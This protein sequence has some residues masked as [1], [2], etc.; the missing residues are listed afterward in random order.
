MNGVAL[1]EDPIAPAEIRGEFKPIATNTT[2]LQLGEVLPKLAQQSQH[3]TLVRSIG[4]D[5]KG[6]RNHG[7]AIY[8]LMT[9]HSPTNFSP[10]GLAVPPSREDLPSVGANV[11][12]YRPAQRGRFSNVAAGAAVMEGR[13]VGVGQSA[14]LHGAAFDPYTIY[15]DGDALGTFAV[16][17]E[18][19]PA[20]LDDADAW[21]HDLGV[22]HSVTGTTLSV[23]RTA[24]VPSPPGPPRI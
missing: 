3:Y 7:A 22:T 6:L 15:D 23:V 20:D 18:Q 9:G 5:P 19:A 16:D 12:R 10:T 17:Q 1:M 11:A 24:T 21:W 14:G 4:V 13:V 2:G 8:M